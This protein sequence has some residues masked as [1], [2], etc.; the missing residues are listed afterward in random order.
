MNK[1]SKPLPLPDCMMPD[2]GDCCIAHH[3][4]LGRYREA[5][6]E[7]DRLEQALRDAPHDEDCAIYR[8]SG[9]SITDGEFGLNEY[10]NQCDCFKSV[11]KDSGDE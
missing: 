1:H 10:G 7:I 11:I 2:G 3:E 5:V 8:V 9:V 4:L 6:A